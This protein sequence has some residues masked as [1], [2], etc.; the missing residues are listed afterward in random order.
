MQDIL[1]AQLAKGILGDLGQDFQSILN[2]TNTDL[3]KRFLLDCSKPDDYYTV[4]CEKK[5]L[6]DVANK[7]LVSSCAVTKVEMGVVEQQKQMCMQKNETQLS[8]QMQSG[9]EEVAIFH[10]RLEL[11]D[12][13][14]CH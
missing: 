8:Q 13:F 11:V 7:K 3:I 6:W 1:E 10:E 5:L 12:C 9:D 2:G 4:V 14:L